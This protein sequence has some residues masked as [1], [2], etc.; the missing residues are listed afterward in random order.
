MAT[1]PSG[2]RASVFD[3]YGTLFN[4]ASAAAGCHDVLGDRIGPLT[5]LWRDTQLQYTWLRSL[6]SRHVDFWQVT[7]DALDF[8]LETRGIDEPL[9]R[10]RLL[11]LYRTLD[12]FPEVPAML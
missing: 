5:V 6:Q 3:A 12:T 2:I 7:C 10:V 11:D 4:Y 8:A 9:L 1:A